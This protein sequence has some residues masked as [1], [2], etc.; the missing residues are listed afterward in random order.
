MN[1]VTAYGI[2]GYNYILERATNLAPAVWISVS[3]NTAA[4]NGVI[5]AEDAFSDL[6]G[7]APASAYYR[8]KWQP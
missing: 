8:L 4:T 7:T 1:T 2:P 5:S 3:T 6:G